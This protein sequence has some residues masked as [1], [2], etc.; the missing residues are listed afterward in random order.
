[1]LVACADAP[2]APT[3]HNMS[4]ASPTKNARLIFVNEILKL[5]IVLF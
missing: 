1:M 2:V 5:Q 4:T 3:P